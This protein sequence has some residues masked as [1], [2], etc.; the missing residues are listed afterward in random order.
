MYSEEQPNQ[1]PE[2]VKSEK[3]QEEK[4][5]KKI[6][7]K[8]VKETL[9]KKGVDGIDFIGTNNKDHALFI[10]QDKVFKST[11]KEKVEAY[12]KDSILFDN[13]AGDVIGFAA[14]FF[15][16][17]INDPDLGIGIAAT[18]ATAGFG[19]AAKGGLAALKAAGYTNK[20]IRLQKSLQT[21][22]KGL[23]ISTAFATGELPS[24]MQ[25]M[26]HLKRLSYIGGS[27]A[28]LNTIASAKDQTTR[29][30]QH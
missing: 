24:F 22:Q 18:V 15:T 27:G 25:K 21:I 11:L 29:M 12:Q 28:V 1:N 20:A 4:S 19:T 8:E 30:Q 7:T 14:D 3:V 6:Q 23:S 17:A 9:S 16:T 26:G 5:E 2:T 13:F 10:L